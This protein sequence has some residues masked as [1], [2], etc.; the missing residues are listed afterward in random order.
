VLV[1]LS[2]GEDNASKLTFNKLREN[3]KQSSALLYAI[4]VP[5]KLSDESALS[6]EGQGVLD[7]LSSIS[8]A[9]SYYPRSNKD[10]LAIADQI[11]LQLR[12]QYRISFKPSSATPDNKWHA[13]KVKLTLPEK[14]DKGRKFGHLN[15]HSRSGYFDR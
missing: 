12:N 2:D 14:D 11:S 15:I 1:L 8:G 5:P 3:I 4:G 7:E 10:M 13:V 6:M 9:N